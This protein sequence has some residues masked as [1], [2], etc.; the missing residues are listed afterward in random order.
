MRHA[1]LA[2]LLATA[3]PVAL[4]AWADPAYLTVT[5]QGEVSATPDQVIINAGVTSSAKTARE[6]LAQ[7][8]QTMTSVFAALK[9]QGVSE[10]AIRTAN[11][12]LSPQYAPAAQGMMAFPN[13]RPIIGYRV[14]NNV[15]VRLDDV[16]HAGT[17]LDA[18]VAAGANQ[19]NGLSYVFKNNEGFLTSAR[20]AAVKSAFDHAKTYA[21]AAG[22]TLGSLHT[23]S[24]TNNSFMPG[25]PP[26]A[27]MSYAA[28]L[29]SPPP[30]GVGEQ[31]L[32]A[33]VT[34]SWEIK[35]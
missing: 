15:T 5:G 1:L 21:A 24:D 20:E 14:S 33:T 4:P 25:Y 16:S 11:F 34:V 30:I 27:A 3:T 23:I 9:K 29:A 32:R 8:S 13:D 26:M 18:L 12:N 2:A 22:V 28:A 35:Q 10:R 6:A 31:T 7:N 19:A 17:V